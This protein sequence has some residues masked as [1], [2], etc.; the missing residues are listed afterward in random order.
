MKTSQP[1]RALLIAIA[2]LALGF[3]H[4]SGQPTASAPVGCMSYSV[5]SGATRAFGL[6][7]LELSTLTG[8][9]STVTSNTIGV[10]GVNWTANQF[11]SGGAVY[12][13]TVRTGSQAGRTLLVLGN[14]ANTLTLDVEDTP[15]NTA[16]FVVTPGVDTF[17]LFQGDTLGSLFGTTA[18]GSGN[19]PS[20]LK[21]GT[22][23][24]NA[25][26]IQL[27]NGSAFLRYYFSTTTG[28]WIL[29][30][31]TTNQNGLILY[32]DDGM[33][34]TRRG[35][36]GSLTFQGR[37]PS[38]KQLTKAPGGTTSVISL[39]FPTSTTLGNLNFGVP[40]TWITGSSSS[41][42]DNVSIWSGSTW[43]VY[44]KNTSNQWRRSSGS[45]ADQTNLA[46]PAGTSIRITKRGTATGSTSF[47]GQ[48]LPY[49]L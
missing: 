9:A 37:V 41:V 49:G 7:L 22:S 33:L 10:T 31:S 47:L 43:T 32:P 13:A 2:S 38:T 14:T 48:T 24:S 18:D 45:S 20:G 16:G 36:T 15:L 28:T 21:A 8:I 25:D 19:L 35:A 27:Y 6:P 26:S 30:G 42:A 5:T 40:G 4:S 34:F 1:P 29:N 46:I 44:Y 17:D 12:F 3:G 39:R 23:T 11:T